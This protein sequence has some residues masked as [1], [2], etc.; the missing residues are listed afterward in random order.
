M[1]VVFT[2]DYFTATEE[3]VSGNV[4]AQMLF[5]ASLVY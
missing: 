5:T 4:M 3:T 2:S 1:L